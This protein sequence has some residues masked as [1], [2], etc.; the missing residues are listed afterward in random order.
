MAE[1]L[2]FN[3]FGSVTPTGPGSLGSM[4]YLKSTP[5]LMAMDGIHS[6]GYPNS[7]N[8]QRIK[9]FSYNFC[10]INIQINAFIDIYL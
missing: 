5:Y 4:S 2:G 6:M 8:P 1:D 7:G 9:N 10:N 3:P